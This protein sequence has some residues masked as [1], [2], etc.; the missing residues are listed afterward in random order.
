[1]DDRNDALLK[2]VLCGTNYG[3]SYVPAIEGPIFTLAGILARGSERSVKLATRLD[4]PL[5][6]SA[7]DVAD[8]VKL[9]VVALP[10]P[11]A[12]DVATALLARRIHVLIEH[13]VAADVLRELRTHAK[14]SSVTL[15]VCSHFPELS[16]ARAFVQE[17]RRRSEVRRP[18]Y[19]SVVTAPRLA[20]ATFDLL[21][22]ALGGLNGSSLER[23]SANVNGPAYPFESFRGVVNEIPVRVQC[24]RTI[25]AVDDGSDMPVPQRIEV[26]FEDGNV[27]LLGPAGPVIWSEKLGYAL[28]GHPGPL[29]VNAG[30]P[31]GTFADLMKDRVV[32]NRRTLT[33]IHEQMLGRK[34]PPHQTTEW[35]VRVAELMNIVR[36]AQIRVG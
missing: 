23:E 3:A 32:A 28:L 1:M 13:P 8:D 24:S 20:Y 17:C 11:A 4:V 15:N 10:P 26:G 36:S 21:G 22:R 12:E 31:S 14:R 34:E 5:W 35:L 33:E 27:M 29:W 9:A 25:G 6:T 18:Q 30:A 7:D 19:A 16:A 2:I